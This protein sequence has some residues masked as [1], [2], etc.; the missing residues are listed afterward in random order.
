MILLK[1]IL[2]NPRS[3]FVLLSIAAL[4]LIT[5]CSRTTSYKQYRLK[6]LVVGKN[7]ATSEIIVSHDDIPG[8][9]PAMTMPYKIKDA[10]SFSRVEPGDAITATVI[11]ANAANDYWLEDL[12]IVDSSKRGQ[13]LQTSSPGAAGPGETIPD[14]PLVNQDGKVI[15]LSQFKGK[16]IL[17]TFIY[18]RCPL[19]NFCP[20]ITSH[21]ATIH[22]ELEKNPAV[23][24]KTHLLTISFDPDYDKPP[25]L[26][27]YGLAYLDNSS[28]FDQWD[29][30]SP[31]PNDLRKLAQAFGLEYIQDG[32]QI[33]HSMDTVLISPDGRIKKSWLDNEWHVD[34]VLAALVSE[35]GTDASQPSGV[36]GKSEQ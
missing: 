5:G 4:A 11:V 34:E 20:L 9:M 2:R 7:I 24:G 25:V 19:P 26:K 31:A 17:V 12:Q 33:A 30:A 14:V 32:N 27:K 29:F 35:A 15:H 28:G 3:S 13:V 10:V 8:F 36:A 23:Y 6:G 1:H 21:F 22:R 16:A 18:T